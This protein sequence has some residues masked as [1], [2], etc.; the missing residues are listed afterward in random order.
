MTV[1]TGQYLTTLLQAY[2]VDHVFGIPGIHT[3]ELYRGLENSQIRHITPRHEQGAGFMADG[4]ARVTGKPG[5]CFI[6]SGP[7]MMNI[8]TAMGQAYADSVPM[9]VISTVNAHG[10]MDSGDGWLHE[11][12]DQRGV[13]ENLTAFSR[14][15]HRPEDLPAAMAQAFAVFEGARPRPVHIELPINVLRAS[16]DHLPPPVRAPVLA[17]PAPAHSA[18]Q[19]AKDLL[20]EAAARCMVS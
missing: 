18:I 3:V 14:T 17:P 12:P 1:S 11:M 8:L 6:I 7:G 15:I 2:G 13:V 10:R 16:A 5:I 4:Y 20:S 9:L 19:A